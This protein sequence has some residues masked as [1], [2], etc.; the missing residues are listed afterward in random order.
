LSLNQFLRRAFIAALTFTTGVSLT[1]PWQRPEALDASYSAIYVQRRAIS[2]CDA[3]QN[4]A[5]FSQKNIR[6]RGALYGNTDGT[7]VLN[8]L[9]CNGDG[10]W[11]D[12]SFQPAL[13]EKAETGWFIDLMRKRSRNETMARAEV[14]VVGQLV[15]QTF[16]GES[17]PRLTISKAELEQLTP[18]SIVSF[19]SN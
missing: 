16:P 2:I 1:L 15:S 14:V 12:V 4:P 3:L 11:L 8:E 17:K 7:F 19:V 10:A 6:V 18:V 9:E 13:A 5:Q